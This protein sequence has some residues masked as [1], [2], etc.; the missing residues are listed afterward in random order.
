MEIQSDIALFIIMLESIN[1][2]KALNKISIK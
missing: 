1:Y 2:K